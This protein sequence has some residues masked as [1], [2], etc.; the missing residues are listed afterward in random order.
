M[1]V[2]ANGGM[3]AT[4]C[5]AS[6][7]R[8]RGRHPAT[9]VRHKKYMPHY[10]LSYILQYGSHTCRDHAKTRTPFFFATISCTVFSPLFTTRI[11]SWKNFIFSRSEKK[12]DSLALPSGFRGAGFPRAPLFP[13][14][15]PHACSKHRRT[16]SE[17]KKDVI[18]FSARHFWRVRADGRQTFAKRRFASFFGAMGTKRK[19]GVDGG[20]SEAAQRQSTRHRWTAQH[21]FF[22]SKDKSRRRIQD[23]E[24]NNASR[25]REKEKK[26]KSSPCVDGYKRF[27]SGRG[28]NSGATGREKKRGA[29]TR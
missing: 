9:R 18:A 20:V 27:S 16:G 10:R 6:A 21:F 24:S 17:K 25:K 2:A 3:M 8:V 29:G 23:T 15:H 22:L 26:K 28:E 11:F 19:K 4:G 12:T 1:V 14:P 5:D 7:V 13:T